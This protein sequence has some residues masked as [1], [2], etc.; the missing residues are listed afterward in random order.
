MVVWSRESSPDKGIS[1][2]LSRRWDETDVR[3]ISGGGTSKRSRRAQR[4]RR[5]CHPHI[6]QG[7]NFPVQL[8]AVSVTDLSHENNSSS[9]SEKEASGEV[10]S[11]QKHFIMVF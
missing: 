9:S 4:M 10:S 7:S 6:P 11:N 5:S 2:G 1:F 3:M 8:M